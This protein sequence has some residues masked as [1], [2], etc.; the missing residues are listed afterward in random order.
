MYIFLKVALILFIHYGKCSQNNSPIYKS[1]TI[2]DTKK[3]HKCLC[4]FSSQKE[5]D[6]SVIRMIVK[7]TNEG[8]DSEK[9]ELVEIP[10]N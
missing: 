3:K 7:K 1:T 9:L 2:V 8:T 6:E 4:C 5:E 10:L